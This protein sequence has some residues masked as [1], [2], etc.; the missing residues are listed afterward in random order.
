VIVAS[1]PANAGAHAVAFGAY[2]SGAPDYPSLLD[3]YSAKVGRRPVI[4]VWYRYWSEQA[5]VS[6]Q[7]QA[8][9]DR[10]AV[11]LVTW[12][13]HR[14]DRTG[15]PLTA[16]ARGDHDAYLR[17]SARDAAA[18]GRPIL[19]RFAHEMN[20]K[21]Y[22]WG[23][24]VDGN[25]PADYIAAWR[26]VVGVFRE[27]GATN[28]RW[29]WAP[30]VVDAGTAPFE[31][32]YPGD[33]W[34]DWVG[35]D[36]YNFGAKFG[37]WTSFADIFASS[38]DT[39]T[40]LSPKPLMIT[41]TAANE[42]GGDKAAWIRSGLSCE[43]GTRFPRV[44]GLVWFDRQYDGVDWRTD[45]SPGSLAAFRDVIN[46]P[47]YGLDAT[48]LLDGLDVPGSAT[49]PGCAPS[50]A[51]PLP[52]PPPPRT[53]PPSQHTTP[54]S[55]GSGPVCSLFPR[56]A[57]RVRSD[58]AVSVPVRCTGSGSS[59]CRVLVKIANARRGTRLGSARVAIAP[60]TKATAR[61]KLRRRTHRLLRRHGGLVARAT[62]RS[63]PGCR[64]A[65]TARTRLVRLRTAPGRAARQRDWSTSLGL[66]P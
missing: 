6:Q 16:I 36:G 18:W 47:I 9:A 8:V 57:L 27:E 43:L 29:V 55:S 54:G 53:P 19:V 23:L 49:A 58:W 24:G 56:R 44:R 12:E 20:G 1:F 39:I 17:A 34:V 51:T 14:P 26:H 5:F 31:A 65:S 15:Y 35:L 10:D 38:Y 25:T 63:R 33:E 52:P 3:A 59:R 37:T 62:V 42:L 48:A 30:N 40:R 41:E 60:G 22:P 45:S 32:L 50:P 61:M 7:L 64:T 4:V 2:T 66:A 11:P 13:P 28:V 46:S 21:W